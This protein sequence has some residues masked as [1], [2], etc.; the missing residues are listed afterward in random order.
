LELTLEGRRAK[1]QA[2]HIRCSLRYS[3]KSRT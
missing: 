2:K 3:M 1:Q